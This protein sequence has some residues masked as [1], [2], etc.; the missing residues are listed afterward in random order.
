[1]NR[2][3]FLCRTSAVS[4]LTPLM[5]ESYPQ[6][7]LGIATTSYLGVWRPKDSYEFLEHCHAL[8]A[9]GIQAGVHGDIAGE[10]TARAKISRI[11]ARAEQL[12]M[13]VEAMVAMPRGNDTAAFEQAL[14][15][16]R[17]V[18]AVALRSACLG[19]R[20]YETFDS[21][22]GWQQHVKDSQ[23]SI[24]AALPLLDRYKIPLGVENHKD[25]TAAEMAAVMKKYSSEYFGVCLDFGN[26]I[27]LL[28]DPMDAIEAL[29]PYTVTTHLK[30]MAVDSYRDGFLLS[31]VVLGD[32][33]L[34]LPRAIRL[35][36]QARPKARWL[37][38]MITR[39]P[40]AVPCLT[41]KYWASF[42]DRSGLY[43]ARTLRFVANHKPAKPLP[44]IAQLS[45]EEQLKLEDENVITC[46]KYARE[47]LDL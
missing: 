33:Y 11:R 42:P 19:S 14:K 45:H 47:H 1:M 46:M 36:Q 5:A 31:E 37:L 18:G 22:E 43:L 39:D 38:E 16:A 35:V 10:A 23:A 15:D 20:R 44:R 6:S 13:F 2:R 12:G 9:A 4:L 3:A 41:D 25:W 27:S 34:D 28:D 29:A 26:N 40:L 8:G 30:D 17:D 24:A 21:L 7:K 32:G